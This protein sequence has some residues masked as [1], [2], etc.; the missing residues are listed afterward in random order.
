MTASGLVLIGA[1]LD[2]ALY[3]FDI[4]T[5]KL[6]WNGPLPSSSTATPTTYE[7]GGRQFVVLAAAGGGVFGTGDAI[8]AFAPPKR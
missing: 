7:A 1:T 8:V 3:A 6:L 5:G 4:A 2:P